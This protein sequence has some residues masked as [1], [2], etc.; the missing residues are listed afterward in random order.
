[1]HENC[2]DVCTHTHTHP[3]LSVNSSPNRT[4]TISS[5]EEHQY[6]VVETETP[7]HTDGHGSHYPDRDTG[8][9]QDGPVDHGY[10]EVS[11]QV[12]TG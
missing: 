5:D 9:N 8:E 10:L 4:H 6:A 12:Y 7:F 1:M 2:T 3:T 11:S